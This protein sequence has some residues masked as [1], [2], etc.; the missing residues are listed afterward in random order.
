MR[1]ENGFD[2]VRRPSRSPI[3]AHFD[4]G[5]RGPSEG[6]SGA[7]RSRSS[8]SRSPL[9]RRNASPG[10]PHGDGIGVRCCPTRGGQHPQRLARAAPSAAHP[11]GRPGT[12]RSDACLRRARSPSGTATLHGRI[13]TVFAIGRDGSTILAQIKSSTLPDKAVV[14]CVLDVFKGLD[15]LGPGG[16]IVTV[17]YPIMFFLPMRKILDER[18]FLMSWAITNAHVLPAR[19]NTERTLGTRGGTGFA[20]SSI[21]P[22]PG[23]A[24]A[25]VRAMEAHIGAA[26]T[27]GVNLFTV[28][29][30]GQATAVVEK[31]KCYVTTATCA[32]LGLPDDCEEA[33]DPALV[34]RRGAA[35]RSRAPEGRGG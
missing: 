23:G 8:S 27:V 1:I 2:P 13:D 24:L 33:R 35:P 4:R 25:P 29:Q 16:G 17:G 10:G 31:S 34:S 14:D 15:V 28:A 32:A 3:R 30:D 20:A 7:S 22:P 21:D 6:H 18:G 9:C 5:R 19:T 11:A 12:L 26:K